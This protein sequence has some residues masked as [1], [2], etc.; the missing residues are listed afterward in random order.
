M[1]L[2]VFNA[3]YT[4]TG[5]G[6]RLTPTLT[7]DRKPWHVGGYGQVRRYRTF[8]KAMKAADKRAKKD[9]RKKGKQ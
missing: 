2:H 6:S 3:N 4:Y 1:R 5:D 7:R 8:T 9:A